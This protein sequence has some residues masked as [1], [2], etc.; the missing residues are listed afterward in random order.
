MRVNHKAP[1]TH[2]RKFGQLRMMLLQTNHNP[3]I[4]LKTDMK[5]LFQNET[6]I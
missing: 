1:S 5:K 4:F 2:S 3:L 6:V